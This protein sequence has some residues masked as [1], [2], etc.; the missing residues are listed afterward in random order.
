MNHPRGTGGFTKFIDDYVET[1]KVSFAA[2]LHRFSTRAAERFAA[3]VP[4]LRE[5]GRIAVGAVADLV[6]WDERAIQSRATV[7]K[8]QT[9]SSGV[10][11]AFVNGTALILDR[12]PVKPAVNPGRW[13]K[14]RA[15]ET[16]AQG[17]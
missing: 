14:G 16:P 1:G 11:A 10:V 15:A 6:L 8:P 13:L 12:K 7:D 2:A 3:Y 5:R 4:G 9:P 17:S